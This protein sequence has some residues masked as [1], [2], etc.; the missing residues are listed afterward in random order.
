MQLTLVRVASD[1]ATTE[2]PIRRPRTVI[3]R[4]EDCQIRIPASDISRRHCEV[5]VEDDRVEVIDLDSRN[6]TYVNGER[7][8]RRELSGGDVVVVGPM[9]FVV[10]VNGS[11]AEVNGREVYREATRCVLEA[12][13]GSATSGAAGAKNAAAAGGASG[14]S[15]LL[16]DLGG[17][18]DES[19]SA[20]D[21]AGDSSV[22][23]FDFDFDDEDEDE[24]P[25]L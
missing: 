11:P 16:D 19:G 5:R 17:S 3:G 2:V 10:R 12:G 1:G 15:S 6:G 4:Q 13:G 23:Q 18:D 24:Q 8:Q 7:A 22:F 14:G 25:P 21:D 9:V 20:A